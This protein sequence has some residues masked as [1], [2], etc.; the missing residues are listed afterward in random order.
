VL[1]QRNGSL[2]LPVTV[3]GSTADL[4]RQHWDWQ[5]KRRSLGKL[6]KHHLITNALV[7]GAIPAP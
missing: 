3:F 7:I 6:A 2:A 1:Y 4:R 5:L